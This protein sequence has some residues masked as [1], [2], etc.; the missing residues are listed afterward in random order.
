VDGNGELDG[1]VREIDAA[2]AEVDASD[3]GTPPD[4]IDAQTSLARYININGP[5]HTGVDFPGNWAADTGAGDTCTG[6]SYSASGD[7][8]G[9]VDDDLV[10]GSVFIT[11]GAD[12]I[13]TVPNVP[14][15]THTVTLLFAETYFGP[16]CPGGGGVGARVF[17]IHAEGALLES[18]VD[19]YSEGGC[20][21][22]EAGATPITRS[23]QVAVTGGS[24]DIQLESVKDA[25]ISG[26]AID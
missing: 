14:D 8:A 22:S 19:I 10:R 24:L 15:G 6:I 7:M 25:I 20:V 1:G 13:C 18:N 12:I 9:T 2:K 17:H 11:G 3:G 5:A 16:G 26:I 4:L 23:F 21:K